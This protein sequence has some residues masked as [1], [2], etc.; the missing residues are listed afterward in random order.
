MISLRPSSSCC[1]VVHTSP[2]YHQAATRRRRGSPVLEPSP[3]CPAARRQWPPGSIPEQTFSQ[4]LEGLNS[5]ADIFAKK[6]YYDLDCFACRKIE[7]NEQYMDMG[8]SRAR[9][10]R[11]A[12]QVISSEQEIWRILKKEL[13]ELLD[14]DARTYRYVAFTSPA[15]MLAVDEYTHADGLHVSCRAARRRR[16]HAGA[17]GLHVKDGAAHCGWPHARAPELHVA[18]QCLFCAVLCH[19]SWLITKLAAY[20]I[21]ALMYVV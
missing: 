8:P 18:G 11:A 13:A 2:W 15:E 6:D 19:S 7:T 12:E 5:G 16:P 1:S 4:C 21:A 10:R 20:A 3:P 9:L 14:V 17:P